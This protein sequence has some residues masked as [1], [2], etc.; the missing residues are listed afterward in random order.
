MTTM[1]HDEV[2]ELAATRYLLHEMTDEERDAFEDHY[3]DC[4]VCADEVQKV[5]AFR[6]SVRATQLCTN[7]VEIQPAQ[8]WRRFVAPA[9]AAAAAVVIG[10]ATTEVASVAPLRTEV[11][12]LRKPFM[13]QEVKL[14][15]LR[16]ANS[17][18][19][20]DSSQPIQLEVDVPTD[21]G[22]APY[23]CSVIDARQQ[24]QAAFTVSEERA[25][26]LVPITYRSGGLKPGKYTVRVSDANGKVIREYSIAVH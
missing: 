20:I 6:D 7:V 15:D 23:T 21:R 14:Q 24:A 1:T 4:I 10:V 18:S 13:P 9:M 19:E 11:A 25:K 22:P 12:S 8:G 3:A 16:A 17:T 26:G 5:Y 2:D